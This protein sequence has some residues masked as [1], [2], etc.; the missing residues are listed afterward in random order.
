MLFIGDGY[1]INVSLKSHLDYLF[2]LIAGKQ[3]YDYDLSSSPIY[4]VTSGLQLPWASE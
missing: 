2:I 3:S 1:T 4:S